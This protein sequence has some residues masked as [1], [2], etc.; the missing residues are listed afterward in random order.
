MERE[1]VAVGMSGGVDSCMAL[2]L[3]QRAGWEPVGVSLRLACWKQGAE[4]GADGLRA[5]EEVCG[6]LGVEHHVVDERERFRR[7]VMDFFVSGLKEGLTPNP[8]AECNRS[9]KFSALAEWARG[10]GIGRVATGHYARA[11]VSAET[12]L[13]ELYRPRD[14]PKD[15]SYGM[16]MVPGELLS[17]VVFPLGN[18]LKRDVLALAEK[19]GFWELS[20]KRQSSDLCFLPRGGLRAFVEETVGRSP[21]WVLD[22]SG[23]RV[24]R[25]R[26]L[27]FYTVGQRHGLGLKGL[28]FVKKLDLERNALLVTRDRAGLVQDGAAL[29]GV[30]FISGETPEGE[31]R[32]LAQLRNHAPPVAAALLPEG[33]GGARIAFDR[34]VHA[35]TP[36]QVCAFYSGSRC[37]G[38]AVITG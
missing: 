2:L 24:G 4:S 11:E 22:D 26:G 8:C 15:Q 1:R 9:F 13:G 37:L 35:V 10:R 28:Y 27:H 29:S 33:K 20:R 17:G 36:G 16:C 23:R 6:K 18:A 7:S 19:E 30:R 12:G 5:A 31:I 34:P 38:G 32:V 25:H 21:G 3:L 14:L